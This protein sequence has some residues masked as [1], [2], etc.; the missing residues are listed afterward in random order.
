MKETY[1]M[2][3]FYTP[4][5]QLLSV[6]ELKIVTNMLNKSWSTNL[7]PSELNKRLKRGS[8]FFLVNDIATEEDIA[9]LKECNIKIH[10]ENITVGLVEAIDANTY[11]NYDNIPKDYDLLTNNKQWR[12]PIAYSDTII[13]ADITLL[14]TRRGGDLGRQL[15]EYTLRTIKNERSYK[16]IFSYTPNIEKI[17]DWHEKLG[18]KDTKYIIKNARPWSDSKDVNMMDYS[19]ITKHL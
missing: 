9:Y 6:Q 12:S 15:M 13:L 3:Y 11:G 1:Y 7:M 5:D 19:Q 18:A 16:Y 8:L 4:L 2:A 17:K 14:K 10:K